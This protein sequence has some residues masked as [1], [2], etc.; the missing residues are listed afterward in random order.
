MTNTLFPGQLSI[1]LTNLRLLRAVWKGS[2][3]TRQWSL[4]WQV[5]RWPMLPCWMRVLLQLK[6]WVF[7]IGK[8]TGMIFQLWWSSIHFKGLEKKIQGK[9]R[10]RRDE[11]QS[12]GDII[13]QDIPLHTLFTYY[14][15]CR[16]I[17][18]F[19]AKHVIQMV[20][21]KPLGN[22]TWWPKGLVDTDSSFI[23]LTRIHLRW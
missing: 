2:S 7:V 3:T 20:I 18:K 10:P 23:I 5:W 15:Y 9:L 19:W 13:Q 14:C 4:I 22:E 21:T 17:N 8:I 16:K 6:P 12:G 11:V 1:H